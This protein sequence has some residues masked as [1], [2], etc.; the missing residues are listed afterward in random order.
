MSSITQRNPARRLLLMRLAWTGWVVALIPYTIVFLMWSRAGRP[1]SSSATLRFALWAMALYEAWASFRWRRA[2]AELTTVSAT[3]ES[4][5]NA[6]V[7]LLQ[8]RCLRAIGLCKRSVEDGR[9][10]ADFD[11]GRAGP[12]PRAEPTPH[13]PR[14]TTRGSRATRSAGSL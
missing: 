10:A 12:N 8:R 3:Q 14:R 2:I 6:P 13:N 1:I 5:Q 11:S 9:M 7:A 4:T